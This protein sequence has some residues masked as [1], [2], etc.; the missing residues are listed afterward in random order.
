MIVK[1]KTSY[2]TIREYAVNELSEPHF[3]LRNENAGNID[4]YPESWI[5]TY[6][7]SKATGFDE[8]FT[9]SI[10]MP[11]GGLVFYGKSLE[12]CFAFFKLRR[13]EVIETC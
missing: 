11:T 5:D 13:Y 3:F 4:I 6:G 1:I 10:C 9:H 8:K 12:D 7:F 2:G